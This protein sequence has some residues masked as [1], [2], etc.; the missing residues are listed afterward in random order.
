MTPQVVATTA[1]VAVA[2]NGDVEKAQNAI[3]SLYT[4]IASLNLPLDMGEQNAT[5]EHNSAVINRVFAGSCLLLLPGRCVHHSGGNLR[6]GRFWG[7][8]VHHGGDKSRRMRGRTLMGGTKTKHSV[9]RGRVV[10]AVIVNFSAHEVRVEAVGAASCRKFKHISDH[11]VEACCQ[12]STQ[13]MCPPTRR[14]AILAAERISDRVDPQCVAIHLASVDLAH[15]P[16]THMGDVVV[17]NAQAVAILR[18]LRLA[19]C[20]G[21]LSELVLFSRPENGSLIFTEE[22]LSRCRHG[23]DEKGGG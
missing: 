9:A 23:R 14:R 7:R 5:V 16:A 11:L 18:I 8:C 6:R 3:V 17:L 19:E 22:F 12:S 1:V 20:D 15:D 2:C 13:K 4:T 10:V 21:L